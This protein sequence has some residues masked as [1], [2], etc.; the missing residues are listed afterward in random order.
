MN[1][2]RTLTDYIQV[3]DRFLGSKECSEL[4][5]MFEEHAERAQHV[6]GSHDSHWRVQFDSLP[7][8]EGTELWL[9]L[10]DSIK[11][12]IHLMV[13][14]YLTERNIFYHKKTVLSPFV[15]KRYQQG[16]RFDIH[17][18]Q[19][20]FDTSAR[21][22]AILMYLNDNQTGDTCFPE[23]ELAVRPVEGRALLFPPTLTYPHYGSEVVQGSKYL[24][25]TYLM[26]VKE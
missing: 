4:R 24:L 1:R 14:T 5:A 10:F 12:R 15:L 11:R 22:L 19:A 23:V 3:N 26:H 13:A 20:D 25:Q 2:M 7:V 6:S 16:G 18:D 21:I 9:P 8:Y 17:I